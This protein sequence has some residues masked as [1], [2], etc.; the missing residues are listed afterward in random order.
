MNIVHAVIVVPGNPVALARARTGKRAWYTPKPSLDYQ[1]QIGLAWKATG[2]GALK[3]GQV[4]VTVEAV[5][6]RPAKPAHEWP[7]RPDIDNLLKNVL[8]ALTK[9]G[10]IDDDRRVVSAQTEKR[11]VLPGGAPYLRIVIGKE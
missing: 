2:K 8:D 5:F 6:A 9:V 1:Q 3:D 7:S 11:Y 4:F 10:A